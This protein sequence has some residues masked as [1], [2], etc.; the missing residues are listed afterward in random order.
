ME[1]SEQRYKQ[2][3]QTTRKQR[4]YIKKL[5]KESAMQKQFIK[6]KMAEIERKFIEVDRELN[7]C[8]KYDAYYDD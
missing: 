2:L 7:W 3:I 8:Q 4:K 6:E 5:Q 1:I